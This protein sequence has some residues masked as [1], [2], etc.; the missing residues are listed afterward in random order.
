VASFGAAVNDAGPWSGAFQ[1]R[2]FGPRPLVEDDSVRSATTAVG[3]LR[4]GYRIGRRWQLTAD[5]FN[6]FDRRASDVD[7]DYLSR[8]PGEQAQGIDDIHYHPVEPRTV[9]LTLRAT[10]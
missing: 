6:V 8:L 5:V 3:Y 7:Y 1:L 2:Y 4:V 9:R 10:L